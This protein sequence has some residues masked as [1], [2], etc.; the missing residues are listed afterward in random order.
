MKKILLCLS[1][2]MLIT[3]SAQTQVLKKIKIDRKIET[4][5][6]S[7]FDKKPQHIE[8]YATEDNAYVVEASYEDLKLTK[9]LSAEEYKAIME[10]QVDK[11][12]ILENARVPHLIGQ[13]FSG[14]AIYMWSLPITIFDNTTDNSTAALAVGLFTP[15][16][17]TGAQFLF[18]SH[19]NISSGTAYGSFLGSIEGAAHG[20]V[21]FQS[22]RT[23]FP[24]SLVENMTDFTL[25]Q[26][27]GFTPA[28]FH[29]KFNHVVYGYYHYFAIKDLINGDLGMDNNM[30]DIDAGLATLSSVLE[31]YGS[32]FLSRNSEYLSFGDAL[33]E[34]RTGI[35]G[36]QTIPLILLSF[37]LYNGRESSFNDRIYAATSLAGFAV[38]SYIGLQ[39]SK[40][41]NLSAASGVF[42]YVIP[43]LAHGLTA[44]IGVLMES[45][46]SSEANWYWR[47]YP[48]TFSVLDI[49][50]TYYIYKA[51]AKKE[52]TGMKHDRHDQ[53]KMGLNFYLNPAP[54]FYRNE[55]IRKMPVA[56]LSWNF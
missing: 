45:D 2:I 23:I 33:F 26:T 16:V 27:M 32:L 55:F 37:D 10:R 31:G 42:T 18:T 52:M 36:G 46:P 39:S 7:L 54:L 1:L 12:A 56:G 28:M 30:D 48:I 5:L 47:A 35:I 44:G 9:Q 53:E 15:F 29:R 21:G 6:V 40:V 22:V 24:V 8:L 25:G 13:S 20:V 50:M 19:A 34:M 43:Y 41:N 17:Y 11:L 3:L 38:G 4:Q 51:F 49:G 14:I